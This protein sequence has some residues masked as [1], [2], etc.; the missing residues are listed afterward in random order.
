MNAPDIAVVLAGGQSR[1]MG[2]D[3]A[4]LR[5]DGQTLLARTIGLA[6]R[7]CPMVAVSGR[8]PAPY[9]APGPWFADERPGLGPL[10]AVMTALARYG[11]ACMVLSCDLPGMD[12]A[13]LVRLL[14]AWSRR[15][16]DTLITTFVQAETGLMEALVAVYQPE[17][18]ALLRQAA[19]QGHLKL[20]DAI[21]RER[22]NFV[23]YTPSESRPFFN[24]N[25]PADLAAWLARRP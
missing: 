24:L 19:W 7:F 17:A 9:G 14:G 5:L 6:G 23:V 18:E 16:P 11:R 3:K 12:A 4:A 25:T 22:R 10:G 8:D 13:T 21:P 15:E 2:Q 20:S 1:R